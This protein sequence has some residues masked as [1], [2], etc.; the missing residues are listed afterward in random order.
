MTTAPMTTT[1]VPGGSA[2]RRF[3]ARG[4]WWKALLA[5]VGYL[6]L[7]ELAGFL[8]G[9]AFGDRVGDDIFASPTTVL[10]GLGAPLIV[11]AVILVVFV[12]TSGLARPVFARQTASRRWWMWIAV[13]LVVA[14][15]VL[16]LIGTDYGVYAAGV[17]PMSFFVGL[18]IGFTEEILYRGVVVTVLRE[19]G[20]REWT[21]AVVSSA[22][23]GLSHSVNIFTGQAPLVVGLTVLIAFGFGMMMYLTM[24]VTGS[25]IWPMIL[26]AVTDP[27]TF[28][29]S[30]GIDEDLRNAHNPFLDAAAPFNILL[31]PAALIAM[32]L[33]WR[34][35]VDGVERDD[36]HG[37][38]SL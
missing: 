37:P 1:P 33:L 30:G 25:I 23:F 27:T 26:H 8:L 35:S 29:V 38:V 19:A 5:V 31:I 28:L 14:P 6:G 10:F 17:V 18:F 16:Q 36:G 20:H 4:R 32:I 3:W 2:W 7:Y 21:V 15:I 24:R 13:A 22:V 11:G 34:R 9:W 12:W